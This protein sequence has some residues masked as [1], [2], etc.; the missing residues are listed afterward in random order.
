[1]KGIIEFVIA[2]AAI[3]AVCFIAF[4]RLAAR[5]GKL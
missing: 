3:F 5:R 4:G 1:V 2:A